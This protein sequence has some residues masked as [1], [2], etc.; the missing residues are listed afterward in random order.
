VALATKGRQASRQRRNSCR[1]AFLPF[2]TN[3]R[4]DQ[5]YGAEA[6]GGRWRGMGAY[7]LFHVEREDGATANAS[8]TRGS[9]TFSALSQK[10]RELSSGD[11]LTISMLLATRI[12]K[13]RGSRNRSGAFENRDRNRTDIS[14]RRRDQGKRERCCSDAPG[15]SFRSGRTVSAGGC[16]CSRLA[17]S[18]P[19][20][21]STVV[22]DVIFELA[23]AHGSRRPGYGARSVH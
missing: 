5:H 16:G 18:F 14:G 17:T 23:Y 3:T 19:T 21:L 9:R 10:E 13:L 12:Q 1:E 7:Y 4:T 22:A 11:L 15:S 8:R 6:T 2:L 20:R